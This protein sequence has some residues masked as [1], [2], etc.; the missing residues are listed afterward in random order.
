MTMRA[1]ISRVVQTLREPVSAEKRA[2]LRQRWSGLPPHLRT[3]WQ[4]VGRQFTHCAYT[5]GPAYCALGCSHCYLPKNANGTPLPTLAEMR[6]QIDANRAL[7]G[8]AGGL[9]ITGGDVVDAYWRANRAEELVEIVRYAAD[10]GV[11]PMLM[12]HGQVLLDRPDYLERLVRHGR[13]RHL[14]I[15]IDTTQAGRVGYPAAHVGS[16]EALHP[17]REAFVGLV[18]G[19]RRSTGVSLRAA[20]TVTVTRDNIE[21]IP[22]IL[23]WLLAEPRR[24]SVFRTLSVQTEANVGRTRVSHRPVNADEVWKA[25]CDGAG[26]DLPRDNLWFGH[27]DC[28][29]MTTLLV[30]YPEGRVFNAIPSDP[31]SRQFWGEILR[32]FG[33]VGSR[34]ADGLD[35]NLRRLALVARHP[36]MLTR[37]VGYLLRRMREEHV[38]P[39]LLVDA[40]RGRLRGLNIIQHNFMNGDEL[41]EPRSDKVQ[42]RL[43]ACSFREAVRRDGEWVAVPMCSMNVEEREVLHADQIRTGTAARPVHVRRAGALS[44]GPVAD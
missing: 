10:A 18:L 39:S 13:L 1:S 16:E 21:G 44:H 38:G 17:L 23:R 7:V 27:P 4:V 5:M 15:H 11:V 12:T 37:I 31:P 19:V 32:V 29:N 42:E 40:A 26:L 14:A 34:G 36:L 22:D 20:L 33:G 9:Q 43:A 25:V 8:H 6:A 30:R 41:A 35:A 3:E 28:S 2:L 24:L